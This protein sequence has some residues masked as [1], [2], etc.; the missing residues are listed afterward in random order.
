MAASI[1]PKKLIAPDAEPLPT[2]VDGAQVM[3]GPELVAV[4]LT[5]L[6]P[7]SVVRGD[8]IHLRAVAS[9]RMTPSS[10]RRVVVALGRHLR[11]WLASHVEDGAEAF[12]DVIAEMRSDDDQ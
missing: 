1:D 2:F 10:Y 12:E 3:S 8:G 11:R 7:I 4:I 5:E 9:L 6:S